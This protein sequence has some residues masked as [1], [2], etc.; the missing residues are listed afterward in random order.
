[1]QRQQIGLVTGIVLALLSGVGVIGWASGDT[2]I[3]I[4]DGSLTMQSTIPWN[5][6]QGG[7]DERQHPNSG[8]SITS[9]VVTL[10]GVDQPAVPCTNQVCVV[11][12]YYASTNIKVAGGN[13]GKGLS[14]SPFSAFQNGPSGVLVHKN[15]NSKISHV[16]VTRAGAK[17]FDRATT[18]GTKIVIHYQ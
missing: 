3:V 16:T 2:P 7:G 10:N 18:S 1:M 17:A 12:A 6:F 9:V 8:G 14:V 4:Q 13:N 5:Q 15:Q 11:E